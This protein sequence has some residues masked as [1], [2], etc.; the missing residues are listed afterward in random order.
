MSLL[1]NLLAASDR[2]VDTVGVAG[3]MAMAAFCAVIVIATWR[4]H[5][6]I[7]PAEIGIGAASILAAIG[8]AKTVR[9]R[10]SPSGN[11]PVLP[12]KASDLPQPTQE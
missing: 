5:R 12:E 3:L 4:D 9:D 7:S 1:G 6:Q 8:G 2:Q 10:W 11:P